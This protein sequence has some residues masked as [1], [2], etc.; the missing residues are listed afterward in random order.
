M[1]DVI[2]SDEGK[3]RPVVC[4]CWGRGLVVWIPVDIVMFSA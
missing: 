1:M 4:K 3:K 2:V